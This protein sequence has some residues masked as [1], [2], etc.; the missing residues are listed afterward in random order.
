MNFKLNF[1]QS[2]LMDIVKYQFFSE[3]NNN[4]IL[5]LLKKK[6][7]GTPFNKNTV[8]QIQN[9]IFNTFLE[10]VHNKDIS[11][12]QSN[13]EEVLI[14]LN[15]M[16]LIQCENQILSEQDRQ[17]EQRQEEQRQEQQRQEQRP[18]QRHNQRRQEQRR[19][20]GTQTDSNIIT[21]ATQTQNLILLKNTQMQTDMQTEL[22]KEQSL[23]HFFS[24]DSGKIINHQILKLKTVCLNF[25]LYNIN[26]NNNSFE[27]IE[28]TTKTKI[29]IPIGHYDLTT[30]L[31]TI[32]TCILS[33]TSLINFKVAHDMIRNR[34]RISSSTHFNLHFIDSPK[35]TVNLRT[36]LGFVNTDYM[37]NN[38][39]VSELSNNLHVFN[40]IYVRSSVCDSNASVSTSSGFNYLFKM[41]FDSLKH[42]IV[43]FECE[44]DISVKEHK[45][46]FEFYIYQNKEFRKINQRMEYD[47]LFNIL[48]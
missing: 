14:S 5:E 19:D 44:I 11:V 34:I 2:L 25:N 26:E 16:M 18:E 7:N 29:Y 45:I 48:S 24:D 28:N 31:S 12:S 22:K 40:N 47:A 20:S 10:S 13:I 46:D 4:F 1:N 23:Y 30:L 8:F 37:N 39:Y 9:N 35:A 42:C 3:K 36:L 38:Y 27:I 6:Q 33:K 17:E 21:E 43:R 15:R 32:E 41:S